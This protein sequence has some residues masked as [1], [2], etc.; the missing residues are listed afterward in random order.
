VGWRL[1]PDPRLSRVR[2]PRVTASQAEVIYDAEPVDGVDDPVEVTET[3]GYRIET[4]LTRRGDAIH[5]RG[6]AVRAEACPPPVAFEVAP[7]FGGN[8]VHV[9]LTPHADGVEIRH[10]ADGPPATTDD[11]EALAAWPS[12]VRSRIS[13]TKLRVASSIGSASS[14]ASRSDS[15]SAIIR[16]SRPHAD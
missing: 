1:P 5:S 16:S 11:G 14:S 2:V 10:A 13:I 15:G 7:D 3:R 4:A 8:R 9:A 6:T 12:R